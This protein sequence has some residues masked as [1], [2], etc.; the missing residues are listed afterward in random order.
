MRKKHELV[1]EPIWDKQPW[2]TSKS[3]L[4]FTRYKEARMNGGS[5]ASVVRQFG[6]KP[7]YSIQLEQWS[8]EN[9]W[10]KRVN[11]Y[12]EFLE[13]EK[14]AQELAR[15]KEM[16]S[17]HLYSSEVL[18]KIFNTWLSNNREQIEKLRPETALRFFDVGVR[19]ERLVAQSNITDDPANLFKEAKKLVRSDSEH[20]AVDVQEFVESKYY[21]GQKDA[22]RPKIME[23][24]WE[25]FHGDGADDHL[26]IVL[27]GGIGWGKSYMAEMGLAYMLYKLSCYASP[28]EEFGLAPGSSI[29]FIM[30]SVKLEL[31]KKVLFGQFAQRLSRSKYFREKFPYDKNVMSELRFPNNITILP[32]PSADTSALGLNVFGGILDELSFMNRV[33]RPSSSRFTGDTEYDQAE[34]LYT[35]VVRRMKSRFNVQG[36]V[37]GKLF[38]IS[39]ANYPGDFIDRKIQEAEAEQAAGKK[40]NIFV[41]KFPQWGTF[42]PD[43]LSPER[44]LVEVGD[45][46][47]NSRIIEDRADAIDQ[48]RVVEVPMDYKSDF[49]ADI[50]A[51]IRDLAG[52]PV[53]GVSAFIKQREAIER[54][55]ITHEDLHDKQQLFVTDSVDL[56]KYSGQLW[57]L[58]NREYLA[59]L[60]LTPTGF[61]ISTDLALSGDSCG[62]AIGHVIGTKAVGRSTIWDEEAKK[63]REKPAGEE[64]NIVLDGV[65]EIV[66]P[67]ADQIDINLIG[68]LITLINSRLLVEVVTADSFQSA[69]LLQRMR[70]LINK[71]GRPVR[72][73]VVSVDT[74][75]APY[76]HVKQALR[77]ERLAYPNVEKLKKELRELI[78]DDSRQKIDHPPNGSKDISDAVAAVTYIASL[79]YARHI[80]G[81]GRSILS[82]IDKPVDEQNQPKRP[83]GRRRRI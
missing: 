31:A 26:E 77:D 52:I 23:K 59:Q 18:Q 49:E 7:G 82:G 33:I 81:Q 78:L 47:R 43:R 64:P 68:D 70:K 73:G 28:Q 19:L 62:F 69:A 44:F 38:L 75:I 57:R 45:E 32:I 63:Y 8:S 6:K 41:V 37:P 5:M 22:I 79:R 2:E 61:C 53:G 12:M 66:P 14:E 24:L 36:R 74:T 65:L 3:F 60:A 72:A 34:T 11:A 25:L 27:G 42:P 1:S 71:H 76:M 58:L 13:K 9:R 80:H 51:S 15:I 83:V 17:R 4:W 55:A 29:Y 21:M 10:V 46:T 54:A 48:D 39:S 67:R 40:S 56:T 30:Q 20:C 50:E 35:T 16:N